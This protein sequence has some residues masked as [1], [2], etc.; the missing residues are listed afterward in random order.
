M[1]DEKDTAAK[2][3]QPEP[4]PNA[5]RDARHHKILNAIFILLAIL[6]LIVLFNNCRNP[7]VPV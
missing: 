6:F 3:E 4:D 2:G 5:A 7:M 1:D